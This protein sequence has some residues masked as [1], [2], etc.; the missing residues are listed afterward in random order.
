MRKVYLVTV[1]FLLFVVGE[2]YSQQVDTSFFLR[3][4]NK[5]Y[6]KYRN[7]DGQLLG[8]A[9]SAECQTMRIVFYSIECDRHLKTITMKGR[10]LDSRI[11]DSVGVVGINIFLAR[12]RGT[13]LFK[14]RGIDN[15]AHESKSGSSENQVFPKRFGD[16]L[17]T[18]TFSEADRLYFEGELFDPVEFDIGKLLKH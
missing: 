18:A 5:E 7:G 14:M 1:S 11:S 16:F 17:F 8:C 13:K 10:I 3:L 9:M 15:L 4:K 6:L 12:P 2:V